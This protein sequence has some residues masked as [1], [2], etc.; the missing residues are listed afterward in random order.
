MF[1]WSMKMWLMF[2]ISTTMTSFWHF[3]HNT[4]AQTTSTCLCFQIFLSLFCC[5]HPLRLLKITFGG[6]LN[7]QKKTSF[8]SPTQTA[9]NICLLMILI[10][11]NFVLK[12]GMELWLM[13]PLPPVGFVSAPLL[14]LF[15]TSPID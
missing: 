6:K 14:G 8:Q 9:S 3:T 11:F 10:E 15:R 12:D 2:W 7:S 5:W 1:C 13:S 4:I